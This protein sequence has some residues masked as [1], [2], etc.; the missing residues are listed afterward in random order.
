MSTCTNPV[1]VF[2]RRDGTDVEVPCGTWYGGSQ[3]LCDPCEEKLAKRFPQGWRY[4]P[5]DVCR[6]GRYVGGC[7]ADY[8]CGRCE[9]GEE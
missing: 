5:G 8:M 2:T 1:Y 7:G 6:H 3:K 4:Y 9:S